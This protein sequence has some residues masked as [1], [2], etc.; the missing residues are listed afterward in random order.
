MLCKYDENLVVFGSRLG[1]SLLLRLNEK[2]I[3][4]P[5]S[6]DTMETMNGDENGND[7]HEQSDTINDFTNKTDLSDSDMD[8]IIPNNKTDIIYFASEFGTNESKKQSY[9]Y[10]FEYCDNL[11]N[12]GPCDYAIVGEGDS[13]ETRLL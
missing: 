8:L 1:N 4:D 12:I 7:F 2:P 5:T 3:I 9:T 10:S 6:I 11:I 13:K